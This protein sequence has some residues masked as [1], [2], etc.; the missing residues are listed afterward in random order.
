MPPATVC[1]LNK[2]LYVQIEAWRNRELK[3]TYPYVFL[4]G[5]YLKKNWGGTIENVAI[6]CAGRERGGESGGDRSL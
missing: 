5:I 1:E 4:D 6:G 3:S 2:K